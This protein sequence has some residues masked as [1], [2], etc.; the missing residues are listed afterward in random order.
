ML[1]LQAHADVYKTKH[2]AV[3]LQKVPHG[4]GS[5]TVHSEC[6][7]DL[8]AP[9]PGHSPASAI[10]TGAGVAAGVEGGAA[11]LLLGRGECVQH[12]CRC[13]SDLYTGPHCLVS[14]ECKLI[15][16]PHINTYNIYIH[17]TYTIHTYIHYTY[18]IY[19]YTVYTNSIHIYS[20]HTCILT[21]FYCTAIHV[22]SLQAY[23]GYDDINW[24]PEP[25]LTISW[26]VLPRS[27]L[28]LVGL[29]VL[30]LVAVAAWKRQQDRIDRGGSGRPGYTHAYEPI[31]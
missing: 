19:T 4:G 11:V 29:A 18:A 22:V 1:A 31:P 28:V 6:G 9:R 5:C 20:I 2:D 13:Y 12:K 30:V 17:Y 8:L 24:N 3:P 16:F 15:Y 26:L 14:T 10:G 23:Q 27:L 21:I 7:G 25:E